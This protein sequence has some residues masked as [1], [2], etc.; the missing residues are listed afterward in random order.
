MT[1]SYKVVKSAVQ[2]GVSALA[3]ISKIA[4]YLH[5]PR[6][7][8]GSLALRYANREQRS[9]HRDRMEMWVM[10]SELL[11]QNCLQVD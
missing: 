5:G 11:K 3:S 4:I 9:N 2:S 10:N 1:R 8:R 7:T 6:S